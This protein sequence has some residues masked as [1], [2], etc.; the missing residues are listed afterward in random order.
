MKKSPWLIAGALMLSGCSTMSSADY[1]KPSAEMF[2]QIDGMTRHVFYLDPANNEQDKRVE[3]VAGKE[4]MLDCNRVSLG[5]QI[6]EHDLKGWGYNYFQ[7]EGYTGQGASTLMACP[8]DQEKTKAFVKMYNKDLYRYNSKLPVVVYAP[9]ELDVS[10]R[11][12]APE[13]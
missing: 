6:V 1:T 2:P 3:I 8:P 12:W 10:I 4:M 5:G 9:A 7:V 11:I 13:S